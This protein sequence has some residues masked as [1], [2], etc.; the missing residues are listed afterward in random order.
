MKWRFQLLL[1]FLSLFLTLQAQ[2]KSITLDLPKGTLRETVE[3][4]G[5]Q[6]SYRFF[7]E[8]NLGETQVNDVKRKEMDIHQTLSQVLANTCVTYK[9]E[10]KVVYLTAKTVKKNEQTAQQQEKRRVTGKVF[11]VKGESL[12]GV[13][14]VKE[15]TTNA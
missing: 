13:N 7:Y 1:L 11:D 3:K 9:V 8:D 10:G 14:V 5:K 2:A 15:G 12:I 6:T 4:I